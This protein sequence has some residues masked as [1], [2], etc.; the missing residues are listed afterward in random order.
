MGGW[1]R[2]S[3]TSVDTSRLSEQGFGTSMAP[4]RV[5]DVIPKPL[6]KR[7][8]DTGKSVVEGLR[9][10]PEVVLDG[11]HI[12]V[13]MQSHSEHT[14]IVRE[15]YLREDIWC[16]SNID[17]LEENLLCNVI[18]V[19]TVLDE[20]KHRS[21]VVY[22][23]L[24]DILANPTRK[25][26]TFY[27]SV[28]AYVVLTDSSQ[29]TSDG[30]E[31]LPDQ[32][33]YPY[34]EPYDLQKNMS[35]AVVTSDSQNLGIYLTVDCQKSAVSCQSAPQKIKL[36]CTYIERKPGEKVNDRNDRA[37]RVAA[38]WYESHLATSQPG[39]KKDSL[40]V[41]VILITDD[42]ANKAK[43]E[44]EGLKAATSEFNK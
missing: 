11:R 25:F 30:F 2:A 20:V 44:S 32:V 36:R 28:L 42:Y 33:M 37:I 17:V 29:L 10:L 5:D 9:Q 16:G 19:Q 15:H 8:G 34:A 27:T 22:K 21:S 4:S 26:Y 14:K 12:Q 40:N 35:L 1:M 43:A 7:I 18:I 41:R 38:A 3:Q 23:R 6:N 13:A 31:K 39:D 24:R